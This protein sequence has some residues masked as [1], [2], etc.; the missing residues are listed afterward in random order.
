L[1]PTPAPTAAA[2][3]DTCRVEDGGD[4]AS[5]DL[6]DAM[7]GEIDDVCDYRSVELES[8]ACDCSHCDCAQ[9]GDG[10]SSVEDITT[11]I[12]TY[13]SS[14]GGGVLLSAAAVVYKKWWAWRSE[15]PKS[16]SG[17]PIL[18]IRIND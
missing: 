14:V 16:I 3:L 1:T 17:L 4:E 10:R 6:L 2:C 5:C 8:W 9:A 7:Y 18:R 15:R 12:A 13:A 11:E